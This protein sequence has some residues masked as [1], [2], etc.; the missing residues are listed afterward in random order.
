MHISS[1]LN[2]QGMKMNINL[3]VTVRGSQWA[4]V[5]STKRAAIVKTI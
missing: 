4:R 1:W 5:Q 3:E 2:L